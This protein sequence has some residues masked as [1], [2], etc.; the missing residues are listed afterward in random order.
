MPIKTI[1]LPLR[2]SDMSEHMLD[3]AMH[4]AAQHNAHLDV[5]YVHPKTSDMLP[6]ANMG[7]SR[8][9]RTTVLESAARASADQAA[10]LKVLFEQ[11]CKK[12]GLP[13]RTRGQYD[14]TVGA[15]WREASGV[16]SVEVA[17]R[18]R[19]A[20]LMLT[21]KPER[22]DPPPKTFEALLRDTARPLL[23]VPRGR[24]IDNAIS[25]HVMIA[26]NGSSEA[27]S[28]LS[29]SR[30]L[31]R[32]AAKVTVLTSTKREHQLSNGNDVVEYLRC[33]GIDAQCDV[34]DMGTRHVG[35]CIINHCKKQDVELLVS[36]GY[37]RTRV[38]EI[39]LGGV[40]R[41]LIRE[42]HIPVFMVH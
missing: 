1:L 17:N 40:T 38:Q 18:G 8:S 28:A 15:D 16:R 42:A 22:S 2:E 11:A 31:L 14:G 21:P 41:Y 29:A 34:I 33:H 27:G 13:H 19:L 3:S 23:M 24:A 6:F 37:S 36:G 4:I 5:F 30:P 7:L 20:D 12:H 26:W 9:L 10:R 35:E 32:A 25:S 39:F